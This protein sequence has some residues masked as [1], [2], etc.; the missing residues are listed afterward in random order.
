MA[1]QK[2]WDAKVTDVRLK[3]NYTTSEEGN[4]GKYQNLNMK[5]KKDMLIIHHLL[6]L[7]KKQEE[8]QRGASTT[9][10]NCKWVSL[11]PNW[12]KKNLPDMKHI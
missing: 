8:Q 10:S 7:L 9:K 2:K 4:N 3:I 12:K 11:L 1:S 5:I 6:T